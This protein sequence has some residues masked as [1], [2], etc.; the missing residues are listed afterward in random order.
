MS[1]KMINGVIVND[2]DLKTTNCHRTQKPDAYKKDYD[3]DGDKDS[4][5]SK[6][7]VEQD[8]RERKDG[9]GGN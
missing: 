9:P 6:Y 7:V 5:A 3:T 2:K 8:D 4:S 1:K